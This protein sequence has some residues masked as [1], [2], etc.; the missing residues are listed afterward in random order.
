MALSIDAQDIIKVAKGLFEDPNGNTT[1]KVTYI[2]EFEDTRK[3]A[4]SRIAQITFTLKKPMDA[5]EI[6]KRLDNIFPKIA[7]ELENDVA[8]YAGTK[9]LAKQGFTAAH[10]A[11]SSKESIIDVKIFSE[12]AEGVEDGVA[13]GVQPARG[14]LIGR[15]DLR[16]ALE[17]LMKENMLKIMTSGLAGKGPGT[18]LKNRTGRFVNTSQVADVVVSNAVAKRPNLSI[19]Y[20]YMIYPYQVFDPLHTQSPQKNL[21]SHARNPQRIIGESLAKAAKTILGNRYR[22]NIRQVL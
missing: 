3:D 13:V 7:K 6:D 12:I 5:D 1:N 11:E 21:A 22:L 15:K 20:K 10:I 8:A 9:L 4:S 18:P 17:F 2:V 14:R 19:Y 16:A